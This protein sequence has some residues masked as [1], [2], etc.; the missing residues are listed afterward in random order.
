MELF[1]L[2]EDPTPDKICESAP[3]M[4]FNCEVCPFD[5]ETYCIALKAER[6]TAEAVTGLTL[7][8]IADFAD[9]CL[10]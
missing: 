7:T 4:G 8:E 2:L 9:E 6:L 3:N 1:H 10:E 5:G